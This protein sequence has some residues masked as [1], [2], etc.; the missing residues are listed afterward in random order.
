[1]K[2]DFEGGPFYVMNLVNCHTMDRYFLHLHI[3]IFEQYLNKDSI[4]RLSNRNCAYS[5]YFIYL[6]KSIIFSRFYIL[7]TEINRCPLKYQTPIN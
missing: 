1:M 4:L 6:K 2:E 7:P 5:A 3:N